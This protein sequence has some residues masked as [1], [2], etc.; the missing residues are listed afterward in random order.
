MRTVNFH[1]A[2]NQTASRKPTH[3]VQRLMRHRRTILP[4]I[5]LAAST[6]IAAQAAEGPA[7][8][9]ARTIRFAGQDWLVKD[10]AGQLVGP[11]PNV[12]AAAN[13]RVT[14]P[15]LYLGVNPIGRNWT[16]AEV[17]SSAS[18]GYGKYSFTVLLD[19]SNLDP[20]LVLG[21]FTYS[22]DPAF[23]HR[24]IDIELSRWANPT[25]QNAQCV[26]QPYDAPG[27]LIRFQ[28]PAG[29]HEA[30][31]SFTWAPG[32]VTCEV[33]GRSG[34]LPPP[35]F[36]FTHTFTDRIPQ[37]GTAHVHIN[38]WQFQGHPPATNA[39]EQVVISNF[40]FTPL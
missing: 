6:L 30:M 1:E 21:L 36:H 38:L 39:P 19:P 34:D 16:S 18:F 5:V 33:D 37:P 32:R 23:A 3:G 12:F 13:V 9:P 2:K 40:S 27:A 28:V 35:P 11:G 31:Y 20:N 10:S 15:D 24:E 29:Q 14:G 22:D 25:A 8:T 17:I 7:P 4:T 26:V